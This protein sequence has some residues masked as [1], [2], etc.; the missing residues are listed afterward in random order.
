[1]GIVPILD[2]YKKSLTQCWLD[3]SRTDHLRP[4]VHKYTGPVELPTLIHQNL[5]SE[6]RKCDEDVETWRACDAEGCGLQ[7]LNNDE[8]VL[9]M[10][11]KSYSVDDETDED[12]DNNN[13]ESSKSPSNADAFSALETAMEWYKPQS[14]CCPAQRMLL[15][16]VRDIAAKTRRCTMVL[17]K[18]SDY[19]PQ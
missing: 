6:P 8:I 19:L 10:Q 15:K 13:K 2:E 11:E 7:K 4:V 18:I 1:M 3:N 17:R 12:E 9:S 14:E 16:I 5:V